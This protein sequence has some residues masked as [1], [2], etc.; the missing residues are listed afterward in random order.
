MKAKWTIDSLSAGILCI[1]TIAATGCGSSTANVR[2][3]NASPGESAVSAS[4]GGTSIATALAYA[5]AS[6]YTSVT[7]GSET[8][9]VSQSSS[10]ASVLNESISLESSTYYTILV[11][12]YP[13][14]V[15]AVVL[16]DNNAAPASGD[17]NLRIIQAAPSLP[18]ADVYVVAPG[19]S[20]SSVSPTLS[21]LSFE[22]ASGYLPLAAGSYEIYFTAP[23]Q[24]TSYIDSGPLTF[25]TGQVR[26]L[27]GL[28][29]SAGGYTSAVLDDL[30]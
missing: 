12:N 10:S 2:I 22:S 15:A 7:S 9:E 27:V 19:T 3:M 24:K 4:V 23:G 5:T 29:G 17:M 1:A 21:T 16:T 18:S 14:S 25:S 6:G 28:D 13:T 8:L 11:A 20:L 30:N 26:S